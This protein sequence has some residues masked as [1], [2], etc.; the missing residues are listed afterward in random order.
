[1]KRPFWYE[2]HDYR[3]KLPDDAALLRLRDLY[4][5]AMEKSG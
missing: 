3:L 4:L 5:E 1:L 2:N